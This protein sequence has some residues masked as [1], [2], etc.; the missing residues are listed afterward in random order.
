MY[1]CI[2]RA[3]TYIHICLY[4]YNITEGWF[5]CYTT[6]HCIILYYVTLYCIKLYHITSYHIILCYVTLCYIMLN[7]ITTIG[8]LACN[9]HTYIYIYTH[10]R[11]SAFSL[12]LSTSL[13]VY[14]SIHP[15][16]HLATKSQRPTSK[17]HSCKPHDPQVR[18]PKSLNNHSP[19]TQ[20]HETLTAHKPQNPNPL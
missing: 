11:L 5:D 17:P 2:H 18:I 1:V 15:S 7:F 20:T 12:Y 16:I 3:Y 13:P 4:M 6:L 8:C 19:K 10:V 9:I 14:L